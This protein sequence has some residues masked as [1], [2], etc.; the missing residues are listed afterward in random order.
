MPAKLFRKT[1]CKKA[2][3]A[4]NTEREN[5]EYTDAEFGLPEQITHPYFFLTFY[6]S[7][8]F[9]SWAGFYFSYFH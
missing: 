2:G 6:S 3:L 4:V 9:P 7:Y 1:T 8:V 5:S